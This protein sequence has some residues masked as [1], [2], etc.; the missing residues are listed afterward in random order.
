MTHILSRHGEGTS[1]K[2]ISVRLQRHTVEFAERYNFVL[3]R[4][5]NQAL[6]TYIHDLQVDHNLTHDKYWLTHSGAI[7]VAYE[8][9]NRG[10]TPKMVRVRCDLLEYLQINKYK[11]NTAINLACDRWRK[12]ASKG[13]V[14]QYVINAL[15][16][17][18]YV[19]YESNLIR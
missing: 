17:A 8:A 14:A 13:D 10:S 16:K 19:P 5:I 6:K 3:G 18:G 15:T 1:T 9:D 2:L 12:Y 4:F 11:V 7:F